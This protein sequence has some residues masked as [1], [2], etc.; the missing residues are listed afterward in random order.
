MVHRHAPVAYPRTGTEEDPVPP[1]AHADPPPARSPPRAPSRSG[2]RGGNQPH[3]GAPRTWSASPLTPTPPC[4]AGSP[5]TPPALPHCSPSLPATPAPGCAPRSPPTPHSAR[6]SRSAP[7]GSIA[8]GAAPPG[9][10]DQKL[11]RPPRSRAA[12]R[13]MSPRP[14]ETRPGRARPRTLA[15]GD[16]HRGRRGAPT[17]TTEP[18]PSRLPP[19]PRPARPPP[20]SSGRSATARPVPPPALPRRSNA[21]RAT[22]RARCAPRSRRMRLR[23][24]PSWPG[25][26]AIGTPGFGSRWRSIQAHPRSFW[27]A[28]AATGGAGCDGLSPP[29]TPPRLTSAARLARD[30][31]PAV[32][33]GVAAGT[34]TP[35]GLLS[36]LARDRSSRVA[37][38]LIGNPE[39]PDAALEEIARRL[40]G[41]RRPSQVR[42]RDRGHR[43]AG[44]Q[45]CPRPATAASGA[46][47]TS[48]DG[49]RRAGIRRQARPAKVSCT[50]LIRRSRNPASQYAK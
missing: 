49:S 23:R 19:P 15:D 41:A 24:R 46:A 37:L 27:N 9:R 25:S 33:T 16:A 43:D 22:R 39:T 35:A 5:P 47:L 12:R 32:R 2:A 1:S 30:W 45:A 7:E 40:S 17:S 8:A 21:W 42:P 6:R 14:R 3:H 18:P 20:T 29:T 4:A 31:S 44:G 26:P 11:C 48:A 28:S 34:A 10:Q 36:R 38:A 13:P 50:S